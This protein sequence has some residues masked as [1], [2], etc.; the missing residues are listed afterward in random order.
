[1]FLSSTWILFI[2]FSCFIWLF[3]LRFC[4]SLSSQRNHS[5]IPW[6]F[7]LLFCGFFSRFHWFPPWFYCFSSFS[8]FRFG[9]CLS[10]LLVCILKSLSVLSDSTVWE[11]RAIIHFPLTIA[12][13]MFQIFCCVVVLLHLLPGNFYFPSRFFILTHLALNLLS[14]NLCNI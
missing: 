3:W 12:F 7:V 9:S 8:G 2:S 1:M 14:G 5:S 10:K 4:Q 6:F 13:D 11:L